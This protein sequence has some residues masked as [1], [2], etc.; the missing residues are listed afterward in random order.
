MFRRIF[1]PLDGSS[2]AERAIPVAAHLARASGGKVILLQ[3]VHSYLEFMAYPAASPE[4]MQTI[5]DADMHDATNYLKSITRK[6]SLAGIDVETVVTLGQIVPSILS[7]VETHHVDL[8]VMCSH[9]YTGLKRWA[10]GSVAEKIAHQACVPVLLLR[11][12]GPTLVGRYQHLAGPWRALVPLDGSTLA[13]E[14]IVPATQLIAALSAPKQSELHLTRVVGLAN[15][16]HATTSGREAF[17]HK[18]KQYLSKTA[19]HIREGLIANSFADLGLAITWSVTVDNDI[20]SGIVRAAEEGGDA[21]EP[22][23]SDLIVMATHGYSGWQRWSMDSVT[24]RVLHSTKLPL[25]IVRPTITHE[26]GDKKAN[27]VYRL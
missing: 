2:R 23:S 17:T 12:G 10:L 25:L 6:T 18:T 5:M 22:G 19:E 24:E 16:E 26:M 3:I 13:K 9:G 8:I 20:A 4:T 14:A 15:P 7:T 1:I 27:V 21:G 11:E